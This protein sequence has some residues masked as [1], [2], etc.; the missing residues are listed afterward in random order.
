[1]PAMGANTCGGVYAPIY[2][3]IF[4]TTVSF[5][6]TLITIPGNFI[7]CY[8]IVRD[9][10]NELRTPFNY[11]LLSLA[12]TDLIVGVLMDTV[13]TVF[14]L[15][16][17]L[18]VDV[19]D[20]RILHI[21]YFILTTASILSLAALTFDRYMAVVFPVKYKLDLTGR[22]AIIATILIWIIALG[23]SFV[24]FKLGF[25][26]YSFIF[27]NA[28]VIFTFCVLVF[29]YA[30]IFKKLR[31]QI[32]QWKARKP[33]G[34]AERKEGKMK[35]RTMTRENKVIQALVSVL[36]AY[37]M[38]FTP[39]CVMIYMLNLCH[40]CDCELIHWLRD[41]QFVIV[42][43]NSGI[44]PYLYAFRMPQFKKVIVR[45]LPCSRLNREVDIET[46]VSQRGNN[47]EHAQ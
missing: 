34:A 5:L 11:F 16:E 36:V 18:K 2:L 9:P 10:F 20:I 13:S 40:S 14:H 22:R 45:L 17:V 8:A 12:T 4:T 7:V 43:L 39:A 15:T 27:A 38:C 26:F 42:L 23:A 3:S 30:S 28:A 25:I 19:V 32:A 44:N 31:A 29:V 35:L 37:A 47:K 1:M 41:L 6:L 21:L 46:S 33:T 24:Y